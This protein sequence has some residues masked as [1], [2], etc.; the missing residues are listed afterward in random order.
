MTKDKPSL[1]DGTTKIAAHIRFGTISI[2]ELAR[3]AKSLNVIL[4]EKIITRDYCFMIL[5]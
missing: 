5:D 1:F 2:R 3:K 4:M